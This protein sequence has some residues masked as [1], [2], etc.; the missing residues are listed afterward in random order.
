MRII[1]SFRSE[2]VDEGEEGVSLLGHHVSVRVLLARLA[3]KARSDDAFSSFLV[4]GTRGC[5]EVFRVCYLGMAP[6]RVLWS[7]HEGIM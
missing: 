6:Q 5:R 3:G 7:A 4:S 2:K 1:S